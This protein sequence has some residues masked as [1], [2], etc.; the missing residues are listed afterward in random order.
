MIPKGNKIMHHSF[1]LEHAVSYGLEESIIIK[2][3][4]Y[5]CTLHKANNQHFYDGHYWVYCSRKALGDI[6][7]YISDK[8]IRRAVANLIEKEV[9]ITGNYNKNNYDRTKWYAFKNE[10]HFIDPLIGPKGQSNIPKQT[11]EETQGIADTK[12]TETLINQPLDLKANGENQKGQPIPIIKEI[13]INN[14]K[15]K[16]KKEKMTEVKNKANGKRTSGKERKRIDKSSQQTLVNEG[17]LKR[18]NNLKESQILEGEVLNGSINKEEQFKEFW[19]AYPKKMGKQAAFKAY[20]NALQLTTHQ[21][22][23]NAVQQQTKALMIKRK[24][25]YTK[26]PATWLNAGCYDDE[27]TINLSDKEREEL[28]VITKNWKDYNALGCKEGFDIYD[29][30]AYQRFFELGGHL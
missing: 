28:K 8:K 12:N 5:W 26:Y 14:K 7:P 17:N 6:F 10:M 21:H 19:Q 27:V 23:I 22:I 4:Q 15:E 20:L 25:K 30:E 13:Y 1:D 29:P 18:T 2:N 16:Y 24:D 11:H 9:L 3:F